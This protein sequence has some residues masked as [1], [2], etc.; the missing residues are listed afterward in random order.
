MMDFDEILREAI[1]PFKTEA[2]AGSGGTAIWL[3]AFWRMKMRLGREGASPEQRAQFQEAI[4]RAIREASASDLNDGEREAL[5]AIFASAFEGQ[6][7]K[8]KNVAP[9][10]AFLNVVRFPR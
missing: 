1:T 3:A 4:A 5:L 10:T 7:R 8:V 2:L 9:K 6:V